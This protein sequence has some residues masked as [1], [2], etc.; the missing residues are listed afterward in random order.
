MRGSQLVLAA[1]D[2]RRPAHPEEE[3]TAEATDDALLECVLA[4]GGARRRIRHAFIGVSGQQLSLSAASARRH[5]IVSDTGVLVQAVEAGSPAERGALVSSDI[6]V[7]LGD[8]PVS[9][10]DDL[11]R[12]LLADRIDVA[13]TLTVLRRGERR[14]IT[15]VP[16]ER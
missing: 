9:G 1:G 14:T 16:E 8:E 2:G 7:A 12:L 5:G 6:I 13:V 15:V 11:H 4:G 3:A 10:V